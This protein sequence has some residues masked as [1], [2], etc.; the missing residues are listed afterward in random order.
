M[1]TT[2]FYGMSKISPIEAMESE[3]QI[4]V[5]TESP[6]LRRSSRRAIRRGADRVKDIHKDEQAMEKME[7]AIER[8]PEKSGLSGMSYYEQIRQRNITE[9]MALLASLD[10]SADI[11]TLHEQ[12]SEKKNHL[13]R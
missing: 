8:T 13:R 6:P 11:K 9:K 3:V 5:M 2:V 12:V 4:K 1:Q 10:I 7:V